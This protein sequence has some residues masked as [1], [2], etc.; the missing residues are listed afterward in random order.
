MMENEDP[1]SNLRVWISV[2]VKEHLK[3]YSEDESY[4]FKTMELNHRIMN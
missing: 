4:L 1:S 2:R 3:N